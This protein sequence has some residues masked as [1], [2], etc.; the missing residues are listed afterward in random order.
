M[1]IRALVPGD[2]TSM[3]ALLFPSGRARLIPLPFVDNNE[4]PD[5]EYPFWFNSG[6]VVEHFH[7][8]TRTGKVGN[9]K[10][11]ARLHGDEPDA[12]SELGIRHGE[13]ARGV[14]PR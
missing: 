3:D 11:S 8:R 12:A 7:T 14:S 9:Q 6:R 4:R 5:A 13:Y 10:S 2:F 1:T